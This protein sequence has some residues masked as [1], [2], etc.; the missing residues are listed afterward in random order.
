MNEEANA[1]FEC[2][3]DVEHVLKIGREF[4]MEDRMRGAHYDTAKLMCD[5]IEYLY[6]RVPKTDPDWKAICEKCK[7]GEIEP[8]CEYY[9]E[10]NGCN[11]PIKGEHP[12]S[13]PIGNAAALRDTLEGIRLWFIASAN[14]LEED[15]TARVTTRALRKLAKDCDKALAARPRNCDVG[16]SE[17]QSSR[18]REYCLGKDSLECRHYCMQSPKAFDCVCEWAQ[19]QYEKGGAE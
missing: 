7:E 9:G 1:R 11:S 13:Q 8:E 4:Q 16:T 12:K 10:P 14:V 2:C 17:E 19:M 3:R 15:T 6:E 18:M 5:T